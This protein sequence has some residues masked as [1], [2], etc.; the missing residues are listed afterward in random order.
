MQLVLADTANIARNR[1]AAL[2]AW[3][4]GMMMDEAERQRRLYSRSAHHFL[5]SDAFFTSTPA[6]VTVV[7]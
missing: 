6:A 7:L 2:A 3:R 5:R 4:G 1:R